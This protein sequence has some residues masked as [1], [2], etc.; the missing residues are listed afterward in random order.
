MYLD[1]GIV[2]NSRLAVL[3]W[4]RHLEDTEVV[5]G[6]GRRVTVPVIEI[7][8]EVG[9]QGIWSPFAVYDVAVGLNNEA[10]FLETLQCCQ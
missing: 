4:H 3:T 9:T 2:G 1:L 6:H 10:E 5:L 8:N 7:A